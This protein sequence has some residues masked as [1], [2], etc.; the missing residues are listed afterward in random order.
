M[1]VTIYTYLAVYVQV[2]KGY[3]INAILFNHLSFQIISKNIDGN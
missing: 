2:L 3:S 1:D